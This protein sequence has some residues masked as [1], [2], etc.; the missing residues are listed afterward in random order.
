[1]IADDLDDDDAD[2]LLV[3]RGFRVHL[4]LDDDDD[5]G[6][7]RRLRVVGELADAARDEHADVHV[8]ADARGRV[9]LANLRRE[10]VVGKGERQLDHARGSTEPRHVPVVEKRSLVI[11]AHRLVDAFA[12]EEAVIEDRYHRIALGRDASVDVD[13]CRHSGQQAAGS[14]QD[15]PRTDL[16]VSAYSL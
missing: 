2:A 9:G 7:R 16:N 11:R 10:I 5:R 15:V 6:D 14:W 12:V 3:R 13:R 8:A 1:M 4:R